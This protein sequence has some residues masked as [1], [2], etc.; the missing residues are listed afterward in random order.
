MILRDYQKDAVE[1]SLSALSDGKNPVCAIATGGGKSVCIAE[2]C[3]RLDGRI[4]VV[5]HRKELIQQNASTLLRMSDDDIGI[6]SAGIG[7]RESDARVVFAG[8]QSIYRRMDELQESGKFGY[9]IIDECHLVPPPSAQSM[10]GTVLRGCEQARRI[11]FSATPYRLDDGPVFGDDDCWFDTLST[12]IGITWLTERG[13]LSPLVGVKT[14]AKP[15]L[16]AVRTQAG[17]YVTRDL[18]QVSSEESVVNAAVDELIYLASDRRSWLIFAVDRMHA[19]IVH[20]ALSDRGVECRTVLGNTPSDE[21]AEILSGFKARAYRGL[22]NVGVLTTGFDAPNVDCV[23]LLRAT[24]S[25]S[26]CVQMLGRGTRLDDDKSDCLVLD[27]AG[28]LER[29]IPIDGIPDVMRS[30]AL[31]EAEEKEQKRKAKAERERK[32]RHGLEAARGIDPLSNSIF[33][34]SMQ[35]LSVTGVDYM[36]RYAKNYPNRQNLMAMYECRTESGMPRRVTQFVLLEYPGRPGRE[37]AAWFDRRGMNM[38]HDPRRALSMAYRAP[39]PASL[40]VTKDGQW[41]RIVMEQ[42]QEDLFDD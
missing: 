2:L 4:L 33:H 27:M 42:F 28:N 34:E 35:R 24:Q 15:N 36:L 16:D 40:V 37:A 17:D 5:T 8:V 20:D 11:G 10:Y 19:A 9:V 14:A 23:A 39:K 30:P 22:V 41:D 31:A 3:R 12:D 7:K 29:H 25:K 38:P 1:S 21:R 32:I 18:S 26:L 13:Y 6:Y